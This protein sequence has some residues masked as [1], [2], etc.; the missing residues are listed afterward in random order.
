MATRISKT[1]RWNPKLWRAIEKAANAEG[2]G[3]A[4]LL[5]KAFVLYFDAVSKMSK[6]EREKLEAEVRDFLANKERGSKE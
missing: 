2:M 1:N 4:A 6:S 5:E 3:A